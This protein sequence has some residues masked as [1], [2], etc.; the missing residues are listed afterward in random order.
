MRAK[1]RAEERRESDAAAPQAIFLASLCLCASVVIFPFF[2]SPRL[3]ASRSLPLVR[4]EIVD[5]RLRSAQRAGGITLGPHLAEA[6]RERVVE[7]ELAVQRF[8][9]AEDLLQHLGGLQ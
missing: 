7:Q 3:H 1:W 4:Q 2:P 9:E 6:G 8:A 5:R